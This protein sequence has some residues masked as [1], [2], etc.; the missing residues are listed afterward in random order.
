MKVVSPAHR[1]HE[2]D[3]Q[4]ACITERSPLGTKDHP[5]PSP[6]SSLAAPSQVGEEE[7]TGRGL[8]PGLALAL[9]KAQ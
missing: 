2:E 6:G 1:A 9:C 4:L 8:L 7:D 3:W 5:T